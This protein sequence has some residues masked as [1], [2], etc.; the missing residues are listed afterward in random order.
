MR[1][2]L[3]EVYADKNKIDKAMELLDSVGA[4]PL[5]SGRANLIKGKLYFKNSDYAKAR[6]M[7]KKVLADSGSY[8]AEIAGRNLKDIELLEKLNKEIIDK[9]TSK[10]E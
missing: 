7:Y 2:I 8:W 5:L 10:Q 6:E 1:L 4:D 9:E 3:A